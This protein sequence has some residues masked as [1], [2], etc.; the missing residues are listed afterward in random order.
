MK[1]LKN[2]LLSLLFISLATSCNNDD[3]GFYNSEYVSISNLVEIETQP[4]YAVNDYLYVNAFIDRLQTEAN[5]TTPLDLRKSTGNA[6]SFNFTYSLEKKVG[7]EWELVNATANNTIIP[8]GHLFIGGFYAA[9][10]DFDTVDDQYK[11]RAGIKLE[12]AGEYRLSFGYNSGNGEAVE[13]RSDSVGN[14][15]FLNITSAQDD[16]NGNGYYSFVVN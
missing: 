5:Q 4:S 3:D 14:N 16:L 7:T 1:T 8:N 10:A 2:I 9:Y 15:V 6:P 12:T 13:L 11:F